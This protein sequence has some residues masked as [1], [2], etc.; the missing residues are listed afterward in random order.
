MWNLGFACEG[1]WGVTVLLWTKWKGHFSISETEGWAAGPTNQFITER[2]AFKSTPR[3]G[4][5]GVRVSGRRLNLTGE[6]SGELRCNFWRAR[7]AD[8]LQ[9]S[10]GTEGPVIKKSAGRGSSTYKWGLKSGA[11]PRVSQSPAVRRRLLDRRD[12][13]LLHWVKISHWRWSQ[14]SQT[15]FK[16]YNISSFTSCLR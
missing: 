4:V 6:A 16:K 13:T 10:G 8:T 7:E 14:T 3:S 1:W 12:Q 11:G 2:I 5:F 15:I 9:C